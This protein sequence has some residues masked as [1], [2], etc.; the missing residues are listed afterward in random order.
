MSRHASTQHVY[1][2]RRR[3]TRSADDRWLS[4]VCGGVAEYAGIEADLVRL[5]VVLGTLLGGGTLLVA[6]VAAWVLMPQQ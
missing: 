5:I 2:T 3:L 6:Y 4:G 1:P